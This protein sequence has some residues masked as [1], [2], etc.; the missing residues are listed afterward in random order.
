[1]NTISTMQSLRI[2]K[3]TPFQKLLIS[4]PTYARYTA[5]N[6]NTTTNILGETTNNGINAI[7]TGITKGTTNINGAVATIDYVKGT[8]TSKI[9]F[10]SGT[11]PTQYTICSL[12]RYSG[13]TF[14]RILQSIEQNWLLGHW[15]GNRGVHYNGSWKTNQ[16]SIGIQ[17]N[18]LNFCGT[19]GGSTPTNILCDGVSIGIASG[20][21][22]VASSLSVNGGT[23]YPNETSDFELSQLLIWNVVLTSSEIKI[24][25]NAIANYL[26]TGILI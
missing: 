23:L 19:S 21:S 13:T 24:V 11:I 25:S 12:T 5:S 20:F 10:P 8:S 1:M 4:K 7:G 26:A 22:Q 2:N 18:W 9:L 16:S 15:F 14:G 3:L 6:Y 17:T